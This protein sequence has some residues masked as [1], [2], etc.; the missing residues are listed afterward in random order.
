MSSSTST[1]P[2]TSATK[3]NDPVR[4]YLREMGTVPLLTRE[5]EIELAKRIE[6]GQGAVRKA[7]SRS[8]LVIREILFLSEILRKD[9]T[10]VREILVMPDLVVTDENIIEQ[11]TDLT[12]TISEIEKHYK[13]AQQ[14]RQKLQAISRGMKPKMHRS[15]RWSLARTMVVISRLIRGI[16]FSP[17]SAADWL[18]R[19]RRAV[20]ELKAHRAR[21]RAD[22]A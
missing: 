15:L 13:K 11:A 18:G 20:E 2:R 22:P 19:L 16:Q 7:L 21:N 12:A 9:A 10:T 17:R 1:S 5:G 14:F 6:R 4:M 3:T 8:P